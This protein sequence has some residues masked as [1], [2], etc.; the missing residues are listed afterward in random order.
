ML[1]DDI[2]SVLDKFRADY[3]LA[4]ATVCGR[5]VGNTRL[6]ERLA[7]GGDCTRRT[8]EKLVGWVNDYRAANPA[9][10]GK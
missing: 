8:A 1:D 2:I 6:Y 7:S 10:A 3:G 9:G 5:A 4:P